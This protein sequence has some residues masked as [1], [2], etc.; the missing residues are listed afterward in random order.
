MKLRLEW[1]DI[2]TSGL[3]LSDNNTLC[4]RVVKHP[5]S[6]GTIDV[7]YSQIGSISGKHLDEISKLLWD[8]LKVNLITTRHTC[9]IECVEL[10][11]DLVDLKG[12]K[13]GFITNSRYVHMYNGMTTQVIHLYKEYIPCQK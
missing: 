2:S 13:V 4:I 6:C 3:I 11:R 5:T 8:E 12:W 9:A 1:D 7:S 10:E